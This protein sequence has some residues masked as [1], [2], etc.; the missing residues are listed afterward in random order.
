MLHYYV[1]EASQSSGLEKKYRLHVGMVAATVD[2]INFIKLS[3]LKLSYKICFTGKLIN[4][5]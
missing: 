1:N 2:D 4:A 3:L 5:N